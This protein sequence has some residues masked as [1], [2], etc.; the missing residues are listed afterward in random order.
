ME[1]ELI[2]D[3]MRVNQILLNLLSNAV[4][5]TPEGGH[6][7]LDV[8]LVVFTEG[9]GQAEVTVSEYG[10]QVLSEGFF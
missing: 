2:G 8:R 7:R 5:F 6:V 10:N 1:E 4:K 3:P 9:T